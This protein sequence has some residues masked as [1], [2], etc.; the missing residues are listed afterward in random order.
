MQRFRR[1]NNNRLVSRCRALP[2]KFSKR[3]Q[4]F[5]AGLN[6]DSSPTMNIGVYWHLALVA[7]GALELTA[8]LAVPV[9][10]PPQ[11][12]TLPASAGHHGPRL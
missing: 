6:A 9:I 7:F 8:A 5:N 4:N 11:L 12:N 10:Q 2:R 1:Q 3:L